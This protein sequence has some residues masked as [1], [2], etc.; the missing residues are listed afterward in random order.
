MFN[1]VNR[2][3]NCRNKKRTPEYKKFYYI[4]LSK[5][6]SR[7]VGRLLSKNFSRKYPAEKLITQNKMLMRTDKIVFGCTLTE[8]KAFTGA[9]SQNTG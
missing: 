8:F 6:E 1:E 2:L 7:L 9:V 3:D 5:I 4:S